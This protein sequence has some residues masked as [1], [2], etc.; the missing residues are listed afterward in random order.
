MADC[1]VFHCRLCGSRLPTLRLWISHLRLVHSSDPNFSVCCGIDGCQG[2]YTKFSSFNT[3]LYRN[4]RDIICKSSLSNS[5]DG[6]EAFEFDSSNDA[7][8]SSVFTP[9]ATSEPPLELSHSDQLKIS[10]KFL[11]KLKD[12]RG[13]SQAAINDVVEGVQTI[14]SH[15]V[16][17]LKASVEEK[18]GF[19]GINAGEV[20]GLQELFTE[21]KDPFDGIQTPYLQQKFIATNFDYVVSLACICSMHCVRMLH[22]VCTC[23][24]NK[25]TSSFVC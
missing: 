23:N 5:T 25:I 14:F 17:Q 13:I 9:E 19:S 21:F 2:T 10:S 11:I 15:T 16:Q 3:H 24:A 12:S 6:N 20:E 8:F 1:L 7:D 18:L 22:A 4:H